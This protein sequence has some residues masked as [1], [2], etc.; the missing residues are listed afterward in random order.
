MKQTLKVSGHCS[1]LSMSPGDTQAVSAGRN[2]ACHSWEIRGTTVDVATQRGYAAGAVEHSLG[3]LGRENM[4]TK[5]S[6]ALW[7]ARP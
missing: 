6:S 5:H 1:D 4:R 7:A 2:P 3:F